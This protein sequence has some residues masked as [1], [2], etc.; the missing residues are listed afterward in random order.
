MPSCQGWFQGFAADPLLPPTRRCCQRGRL[1][2]PLHVLQRDQRL[3]L[4]V[5]L[6]LLPGVWAPSRVP[7][8]H[9]GT[10]GG[11][12]SA[13]HFT[14]PSSTGGGHKLQK[15]SWVFSG[16]K[17]TRQLCAQGLCSIFSSPQNVGRGQSSHALLACGS[18]AAVG[19][20]LG[21]AG[22]VQRQ[23]RGSVLGER[24]VPKGQGWF[25]RRG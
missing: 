21:W 10:R 19:C 15:P 5:P 17:N 9:G 20:C 3:G 12:V 13:R 23:G 8:P 24:V 18:A 22:S 14:E 7:Q 1:L 16:G 4:L 11:C 2:L 25:Q 6:P